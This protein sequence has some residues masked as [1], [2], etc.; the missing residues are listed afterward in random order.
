MPGKPRPCRV[1]PRVTLAHL[2]TSHGSV[3]GSMLPM[4]VFVAVVCGLVLRR[5]TPEER[6]QLFHR[7]HRAVASGSD[8]RARHHDAHAVWM[9]GVLCG[10]SDPNALGA[11]HA[12]DHRWL[13]RRPRP[14][15][16]ERRRR[17]RR[18]VARRVGSERRAAHD[19]RG[20]VAAGVSD[21]HP[22]RM[23]ASDR[24]HGWTADGRSVDRTS[25][26]SS[27][28][29]RGLCRRGTSRRAV[30][31]GGASDISQRRSGRR[32]VRRL[33]PDG[34]HDDLGIRAAVPADDSRW[35]P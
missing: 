1:I 26:R 27:R 30:E 12:G 21:V 18:P 2:L 6:I 9:R 28:V 17:F 31:S 5:M 10:A 14:H 34:R 24:G 32:R 33:R 16:V 25:G 22:S 35:P 23:A 8:N 29:H 3:L 11:D 7:M 19:Q 13:C 4:I 20:V 15:A